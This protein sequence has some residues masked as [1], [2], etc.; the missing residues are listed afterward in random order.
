MQ[1]SLWQI[2]PLQT[3]GGG[4]MSLYCE[5]STVL[6]ST[7]LEH[8]KMNKRKRQIQNDLFIGSGLNEK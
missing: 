3:R 4:T 8:E 5:Q 2:A 6:R 7:V 1:V